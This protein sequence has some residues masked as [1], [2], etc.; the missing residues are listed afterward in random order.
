MLHKPVPLR[1]M[2]KIWLTPSVLRLR[3]FPLKS[4]SFVPGQF[5]SLTIPHLFSGKP[6]AK[7][8]Y[9]FSNSPEQAL[10]EGIEITVKIVNG[11]LGSEYLK[12]LV[13]GATVLS[14]APYGDLE[15]GANCQDQNLVWIC[16]CTGVGPLKSYLYSEQYYQAPPDRV[17]CVFGVRTPE[18][19]FYQRDLEDSGAQIVYAISKSDRFEIKNSHTLYYPGRVTDY[20]SSLP[21]SWHWHRSKFYLCGQP[22]MIRDVESLLVDGHGIKQTKI[23]KE[24]FGTAFLQKPKAA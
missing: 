15:I 11:G 20:L 16:T 22:N 14:H 18:D 21:K 24:A 4:L 9:S 19:L 17:I 1:V 3:F 13:R 2:D 7:R 23:H 6:I 8:A 10:E 12:S 5:L